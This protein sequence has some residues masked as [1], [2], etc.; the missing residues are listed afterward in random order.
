MFFRYR[1]ISYFITRHFSFG[2]GCRNHELEYVR[3]LKAHN[4]LR[5]SSAKYVGRN[6]KDPIRLIRLCGGDVHD[7][8]YDHERAV[9]CAECLSQYLPI[10]YVKIFQ[11]F[12]R[13]G[14]GMI[15]GVC[16]KPVTKAVV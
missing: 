4:L 6:S 3:G 11:V 7:K 5:R 16:Q 10:D 9:K 2:I 15:W 1:Y 12:Y 13:V 8:S 14:F